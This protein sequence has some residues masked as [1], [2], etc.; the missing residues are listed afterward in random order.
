MSAKQIRSGHQRR[1]LNWL[2]DGSGTVSSIAESLQLRMPHAS[3]ALRQLRERGEVSRDEQGSIRGAQHRLNEAGRARLSEDALARARKHV[4]QRP[5][6]AEA[7]VLGLDGPHVLLGYVKPPRSRL[8]SLPNQG[9]TD[10]ESRPPFSSGRQGGRWAVQRNEEIQWYT[11][12]QFESTEPP[13]SQPTRGTLTEWTEEVDRIGLVRATLLDSQYEWLLSP[14][15][16]F[17]EP[18][19]AADLPSLLTQ[20]EFTLG[21][22][23]GTDLRISPKTGIHAHLTVAVNRSLALNAMSAGALVFE[24]RSQ[25]RSSRHL[26]LDAIRYWLRS[27]HPRMSEEKRN[28]KFKELTRYLLN[29]TGSTPPLA[30]QRQLLTDFGRV[31]WLE[32]NNMSNINFSGTSAKGAEALLEWFAFESNKECVIEWPYPIEENKEILEQ[33]LATGRCRMLVTSEGEHQK[34]RST[35]AV[36]RSE[37]TLTKAVIQLG[38]GTNIPLSFLQAPMERTS[39]T[40]HERVP[41]SAVELMS[42]WKRDDGFDQNLFSETESDLERQQSIWKALA[43]YPEGDEQW[44]NLNESSVPL[45]AWI[46]TPQQHRTSRWIRLR[47]VLPSG[48][49]DLLPI[50]QCETATLISAMPK[51]S[52]EWTLQALEKTRQ[53]FSNNIESILKYQHFLEN[54]ELGSWMATSLL[55]SANQ[56]PE[57]FHELIEKSCISWLDAPHHTLRVLESLFPIGTPL[58]DHIENCLVKCKAAA[59][60]HPQDSNLYVWGALLHHMESDEPMTPEFLRQV[61]GLLPSSWWRA[62]ASEWLQIQLSSTSGRRWLA[63]TVLPWPALLARPTGE[64]GGL[65]AWSTSYPSRRIVLDDVLHIL[66]LDDH[67]GKPALLDVYDMLATSERNEPVHYGRTHPLVGWLARPVESWPAM[68]LDVL[69]QGEPEVGALLYARSF[70]SKLE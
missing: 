39:Q 24:H 1:V 14:G 57:E 60:L 44:A 11:L 68:G 32:S 41:S 65:P 5:T 31:E 51:A 64:R 13:R 27:R 33:I 30:V 37:K 66:L 69:L 12:N 16:W 62:W 7:I 54:D 3:L 36:I 52:P 2:I 46:A 55:L 35:T 34:L 42:A 47:S 48:W 9:I 29:E 26:P 22:A 23:T 61:M 8:L 20:G 58:P 15:T 63:S 67:D 10:G 59:K 19:K 49:A 28:M 6:Q 50:E 17:K 4:S 21:T 43:L 45:A 25:Q 56:M 70:S 40:V 18:E 53:R 38:R